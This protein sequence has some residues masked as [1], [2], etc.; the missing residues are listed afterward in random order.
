M[1]I[2]GLTILTVLLVISSV[3]MV[4]I[5]WHHDKLLDDRRQLR[6]E[7]DTLEEQYWAL[8]DAYYDYQDPTK[9]SFPDPTQMHG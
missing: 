8:L 6:E 4:A 5:A 2:D 3:V 7:L 1:I 9:T